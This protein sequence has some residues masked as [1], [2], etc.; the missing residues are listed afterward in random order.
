MLKVLV[1]VVCTFHLPALERTHKFPSAMERQSDE[2]SVASTDESLFSK[3]S[4][5]SK[6]GSPIAD[7]WESADILPQSSYLRGDSIESLPA[8]LF[9]ASSD[10][11]R[12]LK[13]PHH[14]QGLLT[15]QRSRLSGFRRPRFSTL[16]ARFATFPR[17][18]E[19][20]LEQATH[21]VKWLQPNANAASSSIRKNLCT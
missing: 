2:G 19:P 17:Q 10:H 20:L 18:S 8:S 11:A 21:G 4:E 7:P 5:A 9:S 3:L 12:E 15:D 1:T 6:A 13:Y 16:Y 14:R